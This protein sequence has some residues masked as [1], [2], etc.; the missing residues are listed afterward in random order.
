MV[1]QIVYENKIVCFVLFKNLINVW[2][3]TCDEDDE[4]WDIR[5]Q[6][7]AFY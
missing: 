7:Q 6:M 3:G 4:T 5:I 1:Q 2:G